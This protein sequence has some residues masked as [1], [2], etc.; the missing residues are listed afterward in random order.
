MTLDIRKLKKKDRDLLVYLH[1]NRFMPTDLIRKKFFKSDIWCI[2][3]LNRLCDKGYLLRVKKHRFLKSYYVLSWGSIKALT[4]EGLMLA[5]AFTPVRIYGIEQEHDETVMALR[6]A[7]E[8]EQEMKDVF[9]LT[10]YQMKCGISREILAKFVYGGD[11]RADWEKAKRKK[12]GT[13]WRRWMSH[14]PDAYFEATMEGKRQAFVLEYV[15]TVYRKNKASRMIERNNSMYPGALKL[16]VAAD[17]GKARLMHEQLNGLLR[18]N[19][20]HKWLI[21]TKDEALKYKPFL[22]NFARI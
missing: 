19:D 13:G 16:I 1:S 9:W 5:S 12:E 18:P 4:K 8:S 7:I 6:I 11:Y 17:D 20:R 14:I 15:K 10:D 21:T 2:Q 22:G 3:K